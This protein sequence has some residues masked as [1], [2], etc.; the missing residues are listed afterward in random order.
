MKVY[1]HRLVLVLRKD[2]VGE[3]KLTGSTSEKKKR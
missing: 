3:K 1:K 2:W